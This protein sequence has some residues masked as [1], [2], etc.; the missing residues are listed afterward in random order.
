[1]RST[2][3]VVL[4]RQQTSGSPRSIHALCFKLQGGARRGGRETGHPPL[5]RSLKKPGC[6]RSSKANGAAEVHLRRDLE[7]SRKENALDLAKF[8]DKGVRVKL[9]GGREG[10]LAMFALC[11][12]RRSKMVLGGVLIPN[13]GRLERALGRKCALCCSGRRTQ[14]LR[15]AFESGTG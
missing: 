11:S 3:R 15:S 9:S 13:R 14:R 5:R 1:M 12:A 2:T 10:K 8:I 7:M 6:C 4:L